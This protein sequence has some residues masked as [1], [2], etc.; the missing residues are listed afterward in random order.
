MPPSKTPSVF[1]SYARKDGAVLAKRLQSDLAYQQPNVGFRRA[2]V[3]TV[4]LR[5]RE[6]PLKKLER[7]LDDLWTLLK[8]TAL[9]AVCVL[10]YM[11][12]SFERLGHIVLYVLLPGLLLWKVLIFLLRGADALT[13][14]PR[15]RNCSLAMSQTSVWTRSV[16]TNSEVVLGYGDCIAA[17]QENLW[18]DATKLLYLHGAEPTT[19]ASNRLISTPLRYHLEFYECTH[20]N[21]HAARLTTDDLI[22]DMWQSRFSLRRPTRAVLPEACPL[23]NGRAVPSRIVEVV[24]ASIRHAD[25][26]R[27]D[28]RL[29]GG[30]RL[31]ASL[32][33]PLFQGWRAQNAQERYATLHRH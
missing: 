27:I 21:H 30:L 4:E 2:T 5:S 22:D 19:L 18:P 13:K 23:V 14:H 32:W 1:I 15:C 25:P 29:L 9:F 17:L 20:C 8:W 3:G 11:G 16:K 7:R 28:K 6:F 24:A 31:W 33:E 10:P 26:I 12:V